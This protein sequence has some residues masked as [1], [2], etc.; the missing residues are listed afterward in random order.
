MIELMNALNYLDNFIGARQAIIDL[1]NA[2]R[3]NPEIIPEVIRLI[4][5]KVKNGKTG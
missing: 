1:A 5:L 3:K 2:G 4:K